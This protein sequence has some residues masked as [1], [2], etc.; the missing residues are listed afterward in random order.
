MT[1]LFADAVGSTPLAEQ[2]G[3]SYGQ[4]PSVIEAMAAGLTDETFRETLLHSP[5]REALRRSLLPA[6]EL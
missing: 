2:L 3:D 5:R 1:V 4:A 6:A